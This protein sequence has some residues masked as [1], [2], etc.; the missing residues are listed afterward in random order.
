MIKNKKATSIGS[1]MTW[2]I[3]LFVIVFILVGFIV[4]CG[5][6]YKAKGSSKLELSSQLGYSNSESF[7][8]RTFLNLLNKPDANGKTIVMDLEKDTGSYTFFNEEIVS[9]KDDVQKAL[10]VDCYSA[11]VYFDDNLLTQ[12]GYVGGGKGYSWDKYSNIYFITEKGN[13]VKIDFYGG[14][15]LS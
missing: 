6:I 11:F 12:T 7:A 9:K 14:K 15:C 13:L 2:I 8:L 4:L 5:F 10:G 3:A 1:T